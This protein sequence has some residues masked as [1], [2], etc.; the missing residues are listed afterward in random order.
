ML[1]KGNL[2]ASIVEECQLA[3]LIERG[4]DISQSTV[5]CEIRR[6]GM[7]RKRMQHFSTRRDEDRRVSWWTLP[8]HMG[9]CAGVDWSNLVD[10][11]E[12]GIKLGD[13]RRTFGHSFSGQPARVSAFVSLACNCDHN[14]ILKLDSLALPLWKVTELGPRSVSGYGRSCVHGLPG[15]HEQSCLLSFFETLGFA[16]SGVWF[17]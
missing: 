15:K 1:V 3:L 6:L 10:I 13:S 17:G 9:G 12:A 2:P 4:K 14:I 7:T 8:P 16:S 11:D 5:S